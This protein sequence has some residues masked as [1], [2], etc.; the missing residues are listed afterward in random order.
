MLGWWSWAAARISRRNRSSTPWRFEQVRADDLEHLLPAHE[1]VL[2]QVD[3][4]HAAA[5]QLAEDLVVGMV[6]QARRQGA[7]RRRRGRTSASRRPASTTPSQRG[8]NRGRSTSGSGPGPRGAGRG[9]CR[10]SSRRP[11][12]RHA[13][14][15][16]RCLL[17]RLGRKS[18]SLPRPY[19]CKVWSVG[20]T[21][22]G[23]AI[24]GLLQGSG[25]SDQGFL[26]HG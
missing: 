10:R 24:D 12:S 6:G 19:D 14:H 15:S 2:G 20:C 4:A 3:D 21:A 23:A 17:D 26:S 13:S 8:A 16:S 22:S 11:G 25:E 18:S 5:A 9:S 1:L 7:G